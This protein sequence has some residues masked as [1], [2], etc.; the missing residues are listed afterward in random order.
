MEEPTC[1][2]TDKGS[3]RKGP[4]TTAALS[5]CVINH[6]PSNNHLDPCLG[7]SRPAARGH[8]VRRAARETPTGENRTGK[9]SRLYPRPGQRKLAWAH[10][11]PPWSGRRRE[12]LTH[13]IVVS[14][15]WYRPDNR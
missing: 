4:V 7:R 3:Q 5:D 6:Y 11:E 1:P 12:D 10:S 15:A 13:E 14:F 9:P 2:G 8:E